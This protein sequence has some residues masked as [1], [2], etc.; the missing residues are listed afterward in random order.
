MKF[1]SDLISG[2]FVNNGDGVG[3][4]FRGIL[5]DERIVISQGYGIGLA[6]DV[7]E[8]SGWNRGGRI[9]LAN[10]EGLK[11]VPL[12]LPAYAIPGLH[13]MRQLP[14]SALLQLYI[15]GEGW[16][17]A[18]GRRVKGQGWYSLPEGLIMTDR[19]VQVVLETY[20]KRFHSGIEVEIDMEPQLEYDSALDRVIEYLCGIGQEVAAADQSIARFV[21]ARGGQPALRYMVEHALYMRDPVDLRLEDEPFRESDMQVHERQLSAMACR[22]H[23][24]YPLPGRQE[25]RPT[26]IDWTGEKHLV[27]IGGP[28]EKIFWRMRQGL[29]DRIGRH[30]D[31]QSHQ[32]WTP[33]GNPPT[34]HLQEGEPTWDDR[35]DRPGRVEDML[36]EVCQAVNPEFGT[37]ENVLRDLLILLADAGGFTQFSVLNEVRNCMVRGVLPQVDEG[38]RRVLQL[39]WDRIRVL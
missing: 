6:P 25:G 18:N 23:H 10:A 39:G 15:A 16:L 20:H 9:T 34:Y 32:L 33:V 4:L 37:R 35:K 8:Y 24:P 13:L 14:K 5:P 3:R 19:A 30:Q 21:E 28:A 12:R 7:E 31:W 1:R 26:L 2:L 29:L 36:Q 11:G 38:I 27:M 17:R 22:G